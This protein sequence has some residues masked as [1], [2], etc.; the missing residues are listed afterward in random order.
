MS[1]FSAA[2]LDLSRI[3]RATVFP[4]LSFE[5]IREARMADLKAR[6]TAAGIPYDVESLETDPGAILQ[7][8]SGYRELLAS[9]AIQDATASVLLAFAVGPHLDRL[10]DAVRCERLDGESDERYRAR[11]QLAPEAMSTA[12]TLGG[13][14]YHATKVSTAV[15]DVGIA[16]ISPR[17][18]DAA[19]E[20]TVLS[21]EGTGAPSGDL[22]AAV[23]AAVCAN[24]VK[25]LTDAVIVRGAKVVEYDLKVTLQHLRGPDP[26]MIRSL[27]QAS[28]ATAANRYKRVGGDVPLSALIAAV[29]VA[30][31]ERAAVEVVS[32][33]Y[34]F[35]DVET[36][37]FQAA[38]L[39]S[40][41][42]NTVL[43]DA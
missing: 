35:A 3:D 21:T 12:G 6:L 7:Q 36:L 14:L 5:A 11:I 15:R 34:R 40:A 2:T 23:R 10:G 20:I 43:T 41:I 17:T 29:H 1:R 37:R 16:V 27:A 9:A 31:V 42:I 19:V 8:S 38:H 18:D 26:A 22:I 28:L 25:L 33:P 13:Y 32:Q 39:R 30:G 24:D 4:T